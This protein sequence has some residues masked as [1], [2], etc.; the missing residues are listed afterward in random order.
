MIGLRPR[1]R[2]HDKVEI[3]RCEARPT[4]R[5]DHRELIMSISNAAWQASTENRQRILASDANW[6]RVPPRLVM[7]RTWIALRERLALVCGCDDD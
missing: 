7:G 3:S 5:L 2:S 6:I 1:E 4:I